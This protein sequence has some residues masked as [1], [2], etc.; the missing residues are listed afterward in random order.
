MPEG[1]PARSAE[2]VIVY[3]GKDIS[4]D[5][6]AQLSDPLCRVMLEE[7]LVCLQSKEAGH[8][9]RLGLSTLLQQ[10]EFTNSQALLPVLQT[11]EDDTVL[12][13]L[14]DATDADN[15]TVVR[16]GRENEN[17]L[18]NGVSVIA[19]QYGRS[20][21]TGIVAVIGPTRMDYA[22]VIRAVRDARDTLMDE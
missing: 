4:R 22:K 6:V 2:V 1:H 20:G 10:P 19:S 8:P 18:L 5:M 3:E 21:S 16:I 17:E 7:V 9:Y 15:S 14:I 11:L 13:Q 12:L